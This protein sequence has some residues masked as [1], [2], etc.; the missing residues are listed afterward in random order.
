M[1]DDLMKRLRSLA[2]LLDLHHPAGAKEVRAAA[3]EIE[4]L[5]AAH[6]PAKTRLGFNEDGTLDEI[7]AFDA[8]VHLEQ[9]DSN[10]YWMS[11]T[12][13][14]TTHT[15]WLTARGK[16]TASHE[17]EPAYVPEPPK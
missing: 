16:I 14:G 4:R 12:A 15:I 1:S 8:F 7:V 13:S 3:A 17:D 9:M 11:V 2:K 10:Q 5:R 6:T